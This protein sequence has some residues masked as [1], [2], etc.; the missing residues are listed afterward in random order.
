MLSPV[1]DP[2]AS[3]ALTTAMVW[4]RRGLRLADNRALC[5]ALSQ[6]DRVVPLFVW[7]PVLM[8]ASGPNWLGF[9]AGCVDML[10]RSLDGQLVVRSGDPVR[11]ER[12]GHLRNRSHPWTCGNQTRPHE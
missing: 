2:S 10:N 9:L 6:S 7:D 8:N 1:R 5:A 4:F 11:A 12:Y 3:G